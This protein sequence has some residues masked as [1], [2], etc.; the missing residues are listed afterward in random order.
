M[1]HQKTKQIKL[2]R[3]P[4]GIKT[5]RKKSSDKLINNKF[6]LVNW[7]VEQVTD[8]APMLQ[9]RCALKK[10]HMTMN[11]CAFKRQSHSQREI[12][13]DIKEKIMYDKK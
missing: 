13:C 5:K 7:M 4:Q 9:L 6:G 3:I 1:H 11:K 12:S 2:N 8:V 10:N